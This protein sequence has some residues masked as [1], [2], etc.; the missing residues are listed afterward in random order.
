MPHIDSHL[1]DV[2]LGDQAWQQT[3]RP[4]YIEY[5]KTRETV[6]KDKAKK[7]AAMDKSLAAQ[8]MNEATKV[9]LQINAFEANNWI[10]FNAVNAEVAMRSGNAS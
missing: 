3:V 7:V 9:R 5:L 2:E 1:I 10:G 6:Y 8:H 4:R